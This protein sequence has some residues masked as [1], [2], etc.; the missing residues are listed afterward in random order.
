MKSVSKN[1]RQSTTMD[2]W[3][4]LFAVFY[5]SILLACSSLPTSYRKTPDKLIRD[6]TAIISY[7]KKIGISPIDN[8][9]SIK[10][11]SLEKV[12][13]QALLDSIKLQCKNTMLITPQDPGYSEFLISPPRLAN[14]SIDNFSFSNKGRSE[15]YNAIV[16]GALTAITTREERK[17]IWWFRKKHYY[18]QIL[19]YIDTYDPYDAA[20]IYSEPLMAEFEIRG[21][22]AK[23]I[24]A[25]DEIELPLIKETIKKMA[26]DA[27]DGICSAV[28]SRIWKGFI[29]T[30][31]PKEVT[32]SSGE[33]HGIK[34][35]NQFEVYDSS[36]IVE[37]YGEQKFFVPG[38]KIG[39]I[40]IN[41][42]HSDRSG[43]KVLT[44]DSIPVGSVVIPKFE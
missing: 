9:S 7:K 10:N 43:G 22:D 4:G 27:G 30:S 31:N 5:C 8:Y 18:L 32:L 33:M 1:Y 42:V 44:E 3:L 19:I 38:Y 39:D 41:R 6:V 40:E 20:K 21:E 23:K 16:S 17:G 34:L 35:G 25:G 11:Q 14:G 12:V 26:E 13:E 24:N 2:K 37:G 15:G 29:T 36:R 28:N